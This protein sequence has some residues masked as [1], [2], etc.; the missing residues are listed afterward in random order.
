MLATK[1]EDGIRF[2]RENWQEYF[3]YKWS[4]KFLEDKPEIPGYITV[5]KDHLR[6]YYV[7]WRWY[8]VPFVISLRWLNSLWFSL[9]R[10]INKTGFL[11]IPEGQAIWFWPAY[12][13]L[14]RR[15]RMP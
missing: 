15:K 7:A 11:N 6:Y 14:K 5:Y 1:T 4:D 2:H 3:T 12:L 13:R 10:I 8:L 9:G